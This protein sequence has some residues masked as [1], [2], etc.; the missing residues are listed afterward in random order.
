MDSHVFVVWQI[1]GNSPEIEMFQDVSAAVACRLRVLS[2]AEN[3]RAKF[4]IP[5]TVAIEPNKRISEGL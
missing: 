3:C 4:S 5:P 2:G 1:S